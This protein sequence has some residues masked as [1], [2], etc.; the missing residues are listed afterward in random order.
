MGTP[1]YLAPEQASDPRSVDA[2]ADVYSLGCTFYEL[3][4]GQPPFAGGTWTQKLSRHLTAPAPDVRAARPEVP[5][6]LGLLVGRMMAKRPEDRPQTAAAVAAA[7]AAFDQAPAAAVAPAPTVD[8]VTAETLDVVPVRAGGPT[9]V[10]IPGRRR[11]WPVA[12]AVGGVVLVAVAVAVSLQAFGLLSGNGEPVGNGDGTKGQPD[13]PGGV[14]KEAGKKDPPGDGGKPPVTVTKPD[15]AAGPL[16]AVRHD[17]L[18]RSVAFSPDGKYGLVADKDGTV[19]AWEAAADRKLPPWKPGLTPAKPILTLPDI[20]LD[21]ALELFK[22]GLEFSDLFGKD[23]MG[24]GTAGRALA[25]FQVLGPQ[26]AG[27]PGRNAVVVG[28]LKG[29]L[30]VWSVPEGK[31]LAAIQAHYEGPVL[32]VNCTRDGDQLL[33]FGADG[34]ARVWKGKTWQLYREFQCDLLPVMVAV[35]S[36]DGKRLLLSGPKNALKVWEVE[37]RKH[38]GTL[39]GHPDLV[40][41]AAF[42]PD[43]KYALTGSMDGTARLWEVTGG[44]EVK[45]FADEKVPVTGVAFAPDGGRVL[46]GHSDGSVRLWQAHSGQLVQKYQEHAEGPVVVAFSPGGRRALSAGLDGKVQLWGLPR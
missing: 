16:D 26:V 32:A 7:L 18:L 43:G 28:D 2:R 5:A 37:T 34:M 31:E 15:V 22:A 36:P 27:V 30:R 6:D 11:R 41:C 12:V 29:V 42:S 8:H 20:D 40:L 21:K 4:T 44:K 25:G 13:A 45:R 17:F 35:L 10:A 19:H 9:T 23:L 24:K 3:L 1:D 33:S 38:A 46:T 39:A 14:V